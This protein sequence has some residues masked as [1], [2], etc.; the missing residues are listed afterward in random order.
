MHSQYM[1]FLG[2]CFWRVLESY[3]EF[4]S[5]QEMDGIINA[6]SVIPVVRKYELEIKKQ[7]KYP[8]ALIV[9]FRH[10]Q[11]EPTRNSGT[12]V[13]FSLQQQAIVAQV[14]GSTTYMD[15]KTARPVDIR[16]LGNG[17]PALFEGFTKK[18]ES[19]AAR[20]KSWEEHHP[21]LKE[22]TGSKL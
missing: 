4:L 22:R 2:T 15:V 17:F 8:D 19:A 18:A 13:L 1:T 16:T 10:E 5:Q 12:T 3:D 21:A 14:K 7:V 11:I 9:A 6:T 20:K